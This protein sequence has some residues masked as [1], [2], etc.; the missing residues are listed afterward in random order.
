MCGVLEGNSK[1]TIVLYSRLYITSFLE[2][3]GKTTKSRSGFDVSL[4][5]RL[6]IDLFH[7]PTLIHNS[8]IL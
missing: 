5:V 2:R 4:T 7:L 8:F 6:S 1:E 3:V